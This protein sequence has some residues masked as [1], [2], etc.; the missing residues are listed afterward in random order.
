MSLEMAG[1]GD[2]QIRLMISEYLDG[3]LQQ[4]PD[5]RVDLPEWTIPTQFKSAV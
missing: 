1:G 2:G 5:D 3:W 4:Y